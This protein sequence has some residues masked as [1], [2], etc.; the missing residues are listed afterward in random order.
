MSAIGS[1]SLGCAARVIVHLSYE[2]RSR[3]LFLLIRAVTLDELV[4]HD[5]KPSL[6]E[7]WMHDMDMLDVTRIQLHHRLRLQVKGAIWFQTT[8]MIVRLG[9]SDIA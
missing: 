4:E 3:S 5:S 6:I 8:P 2:G 7:E 1:L 9:A